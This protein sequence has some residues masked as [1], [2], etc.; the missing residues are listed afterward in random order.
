MFAIRNK[1]IH[2]TLSLSQTE[3]DKYIASWLLF[4]CFIIFCMVILGGVTRLTGS[5]LSMVEWEPIMGILPPLSQQEWQHTFA[6]YQASPEFIHKNSH[7]N[8]GDFKSIFWFEY[9]HRLLGRS[10]GLIFLVPMLVFFLKGWV[11]KALKPKLIVM[12]IL[13]GLQGLLGWY[14]V[15]SGLVNDPHVSQYRLTAHLGLAFLIVAYIFWIALGL[16]FPKKLFMSNNVGSHVKRISAFITGLIFFAILSGGFVAGTKAGFVYNT[17]PLM[18][19]RLIPEGLFLFDPFWKNFFENIKTIQFDHRVL[20]I[21]VLI[22][23]V[24]FWLYIRQTNLSRHVRIGIN[25][26]LTTVV[27]QVSLGISTLLLNVPTALAVA[28]QGGALLLFVSA[29]YVLYSMRWQHD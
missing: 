28:H 4:C 16:L 25:I 23:V 1:T 27:L 6:L 22:S 24:S 10:I 8:L 15:K 29:L 21:T 26:L 7:M 18:E 17:F 14:M 20:A 19:G 2:T 5:G 13:G 9:A 11:E 3:K 12:F